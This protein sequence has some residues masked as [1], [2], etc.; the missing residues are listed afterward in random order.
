MTT[1]LATRKRLGELE[2]TI[3][4]GIEGYVSAGLALREIRDTE[5]YK[6]S[7]TRFATYCDERWGWK[8]THAYELIAA[9]TVAASLGVRNCGQIPKNE[10]Q[11][12][13]LT[14]LGDP[15]EQVGAWERAQEI[16]AEDDRP[17][18]AADVQQAVDEVSGAEPE[19][20]ELEVHTHDPRIALLKEARKHIREA[21]RVA[22]DEFQAR[23]Y[24]LIDQIRDLL[25]EIENE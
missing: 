3:E 17:V 20:P 21:H 11:A 14:E 16:A 4:K 19:T 18:I 1:A 24:I 7:Y 15:D 5:L 2:A 13:P 12:R 9:A 22:K 23:I 8:K 25:K 10:G 6:Q